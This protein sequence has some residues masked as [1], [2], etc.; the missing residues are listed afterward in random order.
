L[1]RLQRPWFGGKSA[2][3]KRPLQD[4]RLLLLEPRL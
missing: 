3:E 2:T 1:P 4:A